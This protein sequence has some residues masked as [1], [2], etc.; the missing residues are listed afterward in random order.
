MIIS[1]CECEYL[2]GIGGSVNAVVPRINLT[3]TTFSRDHAAEKT[4]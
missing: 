2:T 1:G 4:N 3:S